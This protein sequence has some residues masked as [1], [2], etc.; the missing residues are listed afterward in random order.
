[1]PARRRALARRSPPLLHGATR[2]A[3]PGRRPSHQHHLARGRRPTVHIRSTNRRTADWFKAAIRCD[4]G[5]ITANG[6]T[7]EVDFHEVTDEAALSQ[8][9]AGYRTKYRQYAAIVEHLASPSPR[10]ATLR[11]V[12]AKRD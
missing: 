12:P 5:Q 11:V 3:G 6:R 8:A 2:D 10:A 4:S 7:W 1:M 9:D